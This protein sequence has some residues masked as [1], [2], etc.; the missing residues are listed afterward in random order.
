MKTIISYPIPLDNWSVFRPEVERFVSTLKKFDPG[1]EYELIG[2]CASKPANEEV[3]RLFDGIPHRFIQYDGP[4]LDTGSAQYNAWQ[5]SE[6][7]YMVCMTTRHYFFRSGWLKRMVDARTKH[8]PGLYGI[9]ANRETYP[10]HIC[11]GFMGIDSDDFK[12]YPHH[13]NSRDACHEWEVFFALPWIR[14]LGRVAKL[15]DWDGEYDEPQWF[16][17]P[18]RFRH[19]DQTNLLAW[20]RHSD[21]YRYGTPQLRAQLEAYQLA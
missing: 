1:T 19:G 16:S 18:N 10:L 2:M 11:L 13:V 8:G 7:V 17:K 9:R 15:V 4:G 20:D 3:G 12:L 5:Q 6:N 14:S 21:A